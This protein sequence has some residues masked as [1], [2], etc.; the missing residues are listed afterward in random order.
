LIG[1][2]E[3]TFVILKSLTTGVAAATLVSA[4]AI[5]VTCIAPVSTTAS[6][7]VTPVVFGTPLPMDADPSLTG[8]FTDILNQL[9]DPGVPFGSKG[10]LID[11]PLGLGV[12]FEADRQLKKYAPLSFSL[13]APVVTDNTATT[14]VTATGPHLTK[15]VSAPMTFVNNDGWKVTKTSAMS[16]MQAA[17]AA[18]S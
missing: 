5:G 1:R 17:M 3:R 7:A 9:A 11:G 2:N 13:T 10:N 12:G 16:I 18:G 8:E 6:P 15:P 14:N 4:A